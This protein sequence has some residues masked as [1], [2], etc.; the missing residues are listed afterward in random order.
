MSGHDARHAK[1]TEHLD[2]RYVFHCT[3]S[4]D[5]HLLHLLLV[6]F[7]GNPYILSTSPNHS[8]LGKHHREIS[9]MSKISASW[10]LD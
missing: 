5:C 7:I 10:D 9:I 3:I 2:E 8:G 6:L 1:S 4:F